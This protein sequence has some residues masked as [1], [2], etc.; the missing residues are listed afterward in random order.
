MFGVKGIFSRR[1]CVSA[2]FCILFIWKNNEIYFVVWISGPWLMATQQMR[3]PKSSDIK[4]LAESQCRFKLFRT[5]FTNLPPGT[6]RACDVKGI[7]P[8][9]VDS[10]KI[11]LSRWKAMIAN[12]DSTGQCKGARFYSF[13]KTHSFHRCVAAAANDL[14]DKCKR[15]EQLCIGS[16]KQYISPKGCSEYEI[17]QKTAFARADV[18]RCL[19]FWEDEGNNLR[20]ASKLPKKFPYFKAKAMLNMLA[21]DSYLFFADSRKRAYRRSVLQMA[22]QEAFLLETMRSVLTILRFEGRAKF[23]AR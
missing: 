19:S 7:G 20:T 6:P 4:K 5:I 15:C 22:E 18:K 14:C 12:T 21:F 23:V 8:A 2:I 10:C 17:V 9:N 3:T 11:P 13:G 16:Y 1:V